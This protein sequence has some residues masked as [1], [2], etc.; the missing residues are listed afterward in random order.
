MPLAMTTM[1]GVAVVHSVA[2]KRPV[3]PKPVWTSSTMS[4]MPWRSATSRSAGRN[5]S[6]ARHVAALAEDRLDH[7]RGHVLRVDER[8]EQLVDRVQRE[9]ERVVVGATGRV[10]E[11]VRERHEVDASQQRLV[12]AADLTPELVSDMVPCVRPWKPPRKATIAGRRVASLASL[13]A[14]SIAS[15][16][17]FDR[18]RPYG[19]PSRAFGKRRGSRSWS[20]SPGL[21]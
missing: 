10:A 5:P 17:E 1:S 18:K 3:R 21:W 9:A 15:A 8:R 7:E 2:K 6:G 19:S 20:C 14:A 4:R 11:R 13:T 16:P 12:V